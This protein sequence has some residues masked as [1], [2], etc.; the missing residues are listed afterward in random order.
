MSF[1]Y[2]SFAVVPKPGMQLQVQGA[3]MIPKQET[4]TIPL[5]LYVRIPEDLIGWIGPSL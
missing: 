4:I 1:A 5:N 2:H 3:E